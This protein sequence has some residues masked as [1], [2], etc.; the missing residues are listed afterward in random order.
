MDRFFRTFIYIIAIGGITTAFFVVVASPYIGA[1]ENNIAGQTATVAAPLNGVS[2]AALSEHE[3]DEKAGIMI[4]V[5]D[6]MLSRA[7]GKIITNINDPNYPFE[8]VKEYLKKADILFGNLEGPISGRGENQGS[9]YSF[10]ADPTTALGLTNAGF[11]VVSIANNHILDY[12]P[13]ALL[14]TLVVLNAVGIEPIGGGIDYE[15]AHR[16]VI[17]TV[18][19]TRIA[20][21]AYTNLIP[22][23]YGSEGA[24]PAVSFLDEN[25]MEHDIAAAK[26]VADIVVVT[27]HW[28]EEYETQHNSWQERIAKKAIDSGTSLVIGH[29]PHVVQEVEQY[30]GAF[31]AYSLGNFIFDQNFS[32]DT[33]KG[34][35]FE[36]TVKDKRVTQVKT[37]GISFNESFQPVLNN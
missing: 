36:A 27:F 5:G 22:R 30:N 14:D 6:I 19:D 12:G 25:V 18:G 8:Y 16:G 11:D 24:S 33:G 28:G 10:N 34:L 3:E 29:H 17:K 23:F 37:I 2:G 13:Q 15:H 26:D 9:I 4:F 7:I 20:F 35:I 31:I 1:L 32:E 21:L